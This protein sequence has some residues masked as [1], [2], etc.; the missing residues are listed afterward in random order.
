MTEPAELRL[1]SDLLHEVLD[2]VQVRLAQRAVTAVDPNPPR[3][4]R[5]TPK[6][7]V[8][9]TPYVGM[10]PRQILLALGCLREDIK[11][12]KPVLAEEMSGFNDQRLGG[13]PR[14]EAGRP[15][16]YGLRCKRA[17][18]PGEAWCRPHHPSPPPG[19]PSPAQE[20]R[21]RLRREQLW[22]RPDGRVLEG[23]FALTDAVEDLANT[24]QEVLE[25]AN[26]VQQAGTDAARDGWLTVKQAA[27]YT[28]R[29]ASS[30]NTAARDGSLSGVRASPA[31]SWSF[32]VK[33]LNEW[34]VD[35]AHSSGHYFR[36]YYAK[37]QRPG[38]RR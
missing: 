14:C 18:L 19:P 16:D 1:M 37:Q 11:L 24:T 20:R 36:E 8:D 31:G 15:S 29:A 38:G 25:R 17:A 12:G 32:K 23:L 5:K 33:D 30:V 26:R 35:S 13:A 10:D 27:A 2:G 7:F 28:G 22:Q 34:M 6:R 9:L 4:R 21:S 3:V